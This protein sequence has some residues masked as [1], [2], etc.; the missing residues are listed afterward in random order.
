MNALIWDND[1]A[2]LVNANTYGTV[3]D[4]EAAIIAE[5]GPNDLVAKAAAISNFRVRC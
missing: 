5:L 2:K 4:I 3:A 1:P